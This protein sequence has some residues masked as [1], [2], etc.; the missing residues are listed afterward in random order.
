[1]NIRSSVFSAFCLVAATAVS[2]AALAQ[3]DEGAMVLS[4]PQPGAAIAVYADGL[5]VVREWREI[6]V[7]PENSTLLFSGLYEGI[8]VSTLTV[9]MDGQPPRDLR[10]RRDTVRPDLLLARSV[11]D[12]VT[13]IVE[14]GETG[15]ERQIRGILISVDGGVILYTNDRY[16]V[17]PPGRLAIEEL[18]PGLTP[19]GL[20]VEAGL[21]GQDGL[22]NV[23]LRYV[24]PELSWS[25]DYSAS[26]LPDSSGLILSG[27]Y[28]ITNA[29]DVGYE[30]AL[31]RLVAGE[32]NR[33]PAP[34]PQMAMARMET[35]AAVQAAPAMADSA[36]SQASLGDVHVYDLNERV[37]L[38]AGETVRRT[39]LASVEIPVDK[40]YRLIGNGNVTPDDTRRALD[41]L[42]PEVTLSFENTAEGPLGRALPAGPIRVYGA[43]AEDEANAPAVILG[44]DYGDHFPVGAEAELTL[45]R[46]FDVTAERIV[47]DYE[48]T[49]LSQNRWQN[50]YRAGHRITLSNGRDEP[51]EVELIE[52][53]SGQD[54]ELNRSSHEPAE[55]DAGSVTWRITVP[56]QS[57]VDVNYTVSV[58]P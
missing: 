53:I 29:T 10:V 42:R 40:T 4:E 20:S 31:V 19:D 56:A 2:S 23:E 49:G 1:M 32:T 39:L 52:T 25:A 46:A 22:L 48:T 9:L 47:T 15:A 12:Q 13:W 34:V 14:A 51:V 3:E 35:M 8:D 7:T 38:P 17:M 37:D 11:G 28:M 21:T 44:E 45:G 58:T 18:P 30:D 50:P 27:A 5:S 43:L 33:A 24:T 41:G 55:Q 36:P 6:G 57:D 54:W 26:L 16:E